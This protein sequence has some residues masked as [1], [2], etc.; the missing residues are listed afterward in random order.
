MKDIKELC[1]ELYK[2]DF[3]RRISPE[4]QADALKNYYQETLPEER[5]AYKFSDYLDEAGYDGEMYVCFREFLDNEYKSESYMEELLGNKELISEYKASFEGK[6][7]EES[8]EPIMAKKYIVDHFFQYPFGMK[9]KEDMIALLNILQANGENLDS[10]HDVVFE[11]LDSFMDIFGRWNT[12]KEL[13]ET[14]LEF[15]T[16]FTEREFIDWILERMVELKEDGFDD[17]V[18]ELRTWTDESEASDTKIIRTEDGYVV[19]VWY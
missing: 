13:Y 4:I 3:M 15:N 11:G 8:L 18:E 2:V 16:F 17:P 19:R 10:M 7:V 6:T 12:D 5:A 9:K 1:Y 14:V